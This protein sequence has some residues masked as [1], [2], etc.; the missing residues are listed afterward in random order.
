M[1]EQPIKFLEATKIYLRPFD[2]SDSEH[3]FRALFSP[4][5]R[6][7]TGTQRIFSQAAIGEFI[8]GAA[9]DRS[10]LDLVICTQATNEAVGEVVLNNIDVINRSANVRI[11]IFDPKDWGK[12]YGSEALSLMLDH[13]FGVLN[14]HRIELGVF[15][16]NERAV[17]V[18]EKLGFKREGVLRDSLYYDH[19]YH[20]QIL[21]SILASEWKPR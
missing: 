13:G 18:Y 21:M 16:F 14:L 12:G 10:R 11:A 3:V 20:D 8:A 1:A 2:P 19:Q 6:R 5:G 7:L 15:T 17:H 4:E 9:N